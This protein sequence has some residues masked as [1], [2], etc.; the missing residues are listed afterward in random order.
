MLG[1]LSS[2]GNF[3]NMSRSLSTGDAEQTDGRLRPKKGEFPT[4]AY[5]GPNVQGWLQERYMHAVMTLPVDKM[6]PRGD[7]PASQSRLCRHGMLAIEDKIHNLAPWKGRVIWVEEL[8][9][10]A[11]KTRFTPFPVYFQENWKLWQYFII[12]SDL[13]GCDWRKTAETDLE[14]WIA[15]LEKSQAT[16]EDVTRNPRRQAA[17]H[18]Q[19]QGTYKRTLYLQHPYRHLT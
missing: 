16:T 4:V 1:L 12:D 2:F 17:R 15:A 8:A 6:A 7:A 13:F 18:V 14:K 19:V 9:N 5:I 10:R 3:L 11:K